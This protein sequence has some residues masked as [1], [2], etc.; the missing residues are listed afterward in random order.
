MSDAEWD[1]DEG[2]SDAHRWEKS[3]VET[4]ACPIIDCK[5]DGRR[6]RYVQQSPFTPCPK[7]GISVAQS[8]AAGSTDAQ[9][10]RE[11]MAM[12]RSGRSELVTQSLIR[13]SNGNY[14]QLRR[15]GSINPQGSQYDMRLASAAPHLLEILTQLLNDDLTDEE[16]QQVLED[17]RPLVAQ[18]KKKP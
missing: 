17:A 18:F 11:R 4:V 6:T 5:T 7:C 13:T 10:V 1:S 9:L 2:E 14:I 12:K 3:P 16:Y 8:E 15:D